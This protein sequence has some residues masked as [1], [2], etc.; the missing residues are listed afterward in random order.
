MRVRVVAIL[1]G[2]PEL[3]SLRSVL[4]ES[5]RGDILGRFMSR[6][7]AF[8][9]IS[10]ATELSEV[11]RCY[12]DPAEFEYPLKS[13][14]SFS[15]F[16]FPQAYSQGWRLASSAQDLWECFREEARTRLST[17]SQVQKLSVG[18]EW[19]AGALQYV[20]TT[21]VDFD[22]VHFVFSREHWRDAVRSCG[23]ADSLGLTYE[24]Q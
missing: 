1:F 8:D 17:S 7:Y 19:V 6:F 3:A 2:Q 16:F 5:H 18:M 4:R 24:P 13:E 23:F 21:Y 10:S 9:G 11:M 15:R 20:L 14:C 22:R 12:D